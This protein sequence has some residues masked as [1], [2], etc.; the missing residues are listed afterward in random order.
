MELLIFFLKT[1]FDQKYF[2]K[3]LFLTFT[4]Q[5]FNCFSEKTVMGVTNINIKQYLSYHNFIVYYL[6]DKMNKLIPSYEK[7]NAK[8]FELFLE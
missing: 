8:F 7:R 2:F 4:K 1:V 5:F 3:K 6:K